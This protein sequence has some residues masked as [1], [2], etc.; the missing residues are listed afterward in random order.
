M[1]ILA[2][3]TATS[4]QSVALVGENGLWAAEIVR[5]SP[6]S[7]RIDQPRRWSIMP[8]I[9][10]LLRACHVALRDIDALAVSIGPGSFTGLRVGL[11]TMKGL[12]HGADKPLI[13]V[14]TLHALA[15][16]VSGLGLPVCTVLDAKRDELFLAVFH[17]QHDSDA[18]GP[19]SY[20]MEPQR[21]HVGNVVR[22]LSPHLNHRMIIVGDG[23][24]PLP[25]DAL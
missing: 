24:P 18:H 2:V 11:A 9:D 21:L 3:E 1:T 25:F 6:L 22:A 8:A 5:Q 14:P 19:L 15:Y 13:A 23:A 16:N 7:I 10:R 17:A 20:L 4:L 12:A